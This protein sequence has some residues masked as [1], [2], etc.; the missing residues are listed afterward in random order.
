MP[1]TVTSPRLILSALLFVAAM[2]A[3]I[4]RAQHSAT[5]KLTADA[6]KSLLNG[7]T[8]PNQDNHVSCPAGVT[9]P[10]PGWTQVAA[11]GFEGSVP[12]VIQGTVVT[13][14]HNGGTHAL[15]GPMVGDGSVVDIFNPATSAT[16]EFYESF[17]D[18]ASST[19][20]YGIDYELGRLHT[21]KPGG[22]LAQKC[23][24]GPQPQGPSYLQITS[25]IWVGCESPCF[26]KGCNPIGT[27]FGDSLCC[28]NNIT[29]NGG[30]WRQY[31]FYFK[32]NTCT[33][34]VPKADGSYTFY[35]NGQVLLHHDK[36]NLVG[37]NSFIN[38]TVW[39]EAAGI[40]TSL[41]YGSG[42]DPSKCYPLGAAYPPGYQAYRCSPFSACPAKEVDGSNTCWGSQPGFGR[43]VDDVIVLQK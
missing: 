18:Y 9:Y 39:V 15:Y 1:S 36:V 3:I 35:V 7:C 16:G 30:Y 24:F 29:I 43:W 34:N 27:E 40:Y 10:P 42:T 20:V 28:A 31:E 19:G 32:A 6:P 2:A 38:T 13:T 4:T 8:V 21:D 17:W 25:P 33:N 23:A 37:C 5:K 41:Y 22:G 26:T 11:Q 12:Q 14:N